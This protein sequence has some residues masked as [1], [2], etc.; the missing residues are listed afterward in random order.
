MLITSIFVMRLFRRE[1]FML[2]LK[3][4]CYSN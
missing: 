3:D 2:V 4:N 1:S